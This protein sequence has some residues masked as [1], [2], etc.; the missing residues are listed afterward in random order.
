MTARRPG[1]RSVAVSMVVLAL[2]GALGGYSAAR[3]GSGSPAA[4]SLAGTPFSRAELDPQV[5][6]GLA[7]VAQEE[8][9]DPAAL[10]EM[11]GVGSGALRRSAFVGIDRTGEA[12]VAFFGGTTH[13]DFL[14]AERLL[15]DRPMFVYVTASGT[16]T[17]M[18][19]I[20]AVGLVSASVARVTITRANGEAFDARISRVPRLGIGLFATLAQEADLFPRAAK[21]FSRDARVVAEERIS[22]EGLCSKDDPRCLER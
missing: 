14:P 1:H 20:G 19:R 17:E 4:F 22:S 16:A 9:L 6:A 5:R 8:G 15:H 12:R 13:T 2:G 21:A 11:S 18:R 10:V 3:G 7:H